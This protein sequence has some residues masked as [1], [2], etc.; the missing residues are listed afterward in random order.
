MHGL[1]KKIQ[2]VINS[3]KI[4]LAIC[5][6]FL[7]VASVC[8]PFIWGF[9]IISTSSSRFSFSKKKHWLSHAC[10]RKSF[11]TSY[12][13][14]IFFSSSFKFASLLSSFHKTHANQFHGRIVDNFL[15]AFHLSLLSTRKPFKNLNWKNRMKRVG[16]INN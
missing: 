13:V 2:T 12:V 6:L 14:F 15:N 10:N 11:L 9:I 1:K 3:T 5:S 16:K 7:Y 8:F 4:C